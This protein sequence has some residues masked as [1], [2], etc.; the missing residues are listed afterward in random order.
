MLVGLVAGCSWTPDRLNP[1]DPESSNY[2][3]PPQANR[4]PRID[5]LIVNTECINLPVND[6]CSIIVH[7]AISDADDNLDID[8]VVAAIRDEFGDRRLGLLAYDAA[9]QYWELRREETSLDSAIERYVGARMVVS[10]VDDSG[11]TAERTLTVPS[12][13]TAYP[14]THWPIDLE[15]VCPDYRDFS[16]VRWNGEGQA[17]NME[18]R[19]YFKNLIYVPEYTIG[20]IA[21]QDTFTTVPWPF[22]GSDFNQDVFY[23]WRVFVY[24]Q[25]G[26][27][28]GSFSTTFQYFVTCT[29]SCIGPP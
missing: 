1:Y 13:F 6:H 15:C 8:S 28:A 5:T 17:R 9:S 3:A 2:V 25:L 23:G 27:S 10:V 11:A 18:V 14:S 12:L 7:A 21:V 26:N 20:G 19:F 4:P 24:D 22:S 16:W 29:D